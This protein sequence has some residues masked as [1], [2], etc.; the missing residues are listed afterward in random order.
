MKERLLSLRT[1]YFARS[2]SAHRSLRCRFFNTSSSLEIP[3]LP[4]LNDIVAKVKRNPGRFS[5]F[6]QI[7]LVGVQHFVESTATLIHAII[8]LGVK[9]ERIWLTTKCYS[10]SRQVEAQIRSMGVNVIPPAKPDFPGDYLRAAR[11][12]AITTWEAFSEKENNLQ[13]LIV[14]DE[15]FRLLETMPESVALGKYELAAIEHTEGGLNSAFANAIPSPLIELASSAAKKILEP[16]LIASA[17]I[18]EVSKTIERLNLNKKTIFGVIGN[19]AIGKTI[20]EYL[21]SLGHNVLVYDDNEH[22]FDNIAH[23]KFFRVGSIE[24]VITRAECIF[25]CTGKDITKNLNVFALATRDKHFISCSSEDKEFLSLLKAIGENNRAYIDPMT[26]IVGIS[27]SGS[28][29]VI[30]RGGYPINFNGSLVS[31]PTQQ[32]QLTRGLLLGAFL[33]ATLNAKKLVGDGKTINKTERLS[34]DPYLQSFVVQN[35]KEFQ[36]AGDPRRKFISNFKDSEW[37]KENSGGTYDE[38]ST[39]KELFELSKNDL[40]DSVSSKVSLML[41]PGVKVRSLDE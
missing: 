2:Y 33:Q 27:N 30:I 9:P 29:I 6:S 36:P 26:D 13:K 39:L 22:A 32:I 37:I 17:I 1:S 38:N 23:S 28:K 34:L 11:R 5:D 24:N 40:E 20:T 41:T 21:L 15:G 19:G 16:S 8:Q 35:W 4:V 31:V 14:L 7:G 25:G 3:N 12:T 10:H 18:V